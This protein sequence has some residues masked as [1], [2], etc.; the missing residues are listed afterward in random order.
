MELN[1][2][3]TVYCSG[4]QRIYR[5]RSF[6]DK[7][8]TFFTFFLFFYS[9][10]V[11]RRS[12]WKLLHMRINLYYIFTSHIRALG[13]YQCISLC[14]GMLSFKCLHCTIVLLTPYN[15][16]KGF[17]KTLFTVVPIFM[18]YSPGQERFTRPPNLRNFFIL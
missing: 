18:V 12:F 3:F 4:W 17:L 16:Q 1:A 13:V 2:L 9:G 11:V 10:A 14:A 8:Y 6:E 15:E 7:A 5:V